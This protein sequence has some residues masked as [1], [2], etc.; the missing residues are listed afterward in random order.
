MK[1]LSSKVLR[2]AL[3]AILAICMVVGMCTTALATGNDVIDTEAELAAAIAAGGE[4]VLGGNI[5]ITT[6]LKVTKDVNLDLNGY[7]LTG[8]HNYDNGTNLY[9]F[10]VEAGTLTLDDS[11]AAQTGEISCKYSG[12]ETKGGTFIM[13]GGKITAANAEYTVAVVNY[14]G[15]VVING[16]VI[17]AYDTA[18]TTMAYFTTSATTEIKGGEINLVESDHNYAIFEVGGEYNNGSTNVNVSAGEFNS[19]GSVVIA[20]DD[21][22][23]TVS[24]E[25]TGGAFDDDADISDYIAD[26]YTLG[27]N[28]EIIVAQKYVAI[29]DS[30]SNGYGTSGYYEG[31]DIT[32]Y[33]YYGF[34]REAGYPA[35][36][37]D[38]M[39]WDLAD[40]EGQLAISGM[41]AE[42][43]HAILNDDYNGDAYTKY[44]FMEGGE[45]DNFDDWGR[46]CIVL[47]NGVAGHDSATCDCEAQVRAIFTEQIEGA[48]YISINLGTNTFGTVF[49]HELMNVVSEGWDGEIPEYDAL[50]LETLLADPVLSAQYNAVLEYAKTK[51]DA[52]YVNL[53]DLFA[54]SYVGYLANYTAAFDLIREI[55]PDATIII[56]GLNNLLEGM[57]LTLGEG[58]AAIPVGD[59]VGFMIDAANT[60]ISAISYDDAKVL[61]AE[62]ENLDLMINV[63]G[64]DKFTAESET[65]FGK[66]LAETVAATFAGYGI[67]VPADA[68]ELFIFATP[69]ERDA[70]VTATPGLAQIA[71]FWDA[72]VAG[73]SVTELDVVDVMY[74]MGTGDVLNPGLLH[75]MARATLAEGIGIHPST[76]GHSQIAA[77]IKAAVEE[78]STAGDFAEGNITAAVDGAID[79]ITEYYDEA[80]AYAYDYADENGYIDAAV[81]AIDGVI[82]T[83]ENVDLTA[84]EMT[85]A[86]RADAAAAIAEVIET[87]EA[88]KALLLAADELDEDTLNA[89]IAL[90]NDAY[91]DLEALDE[92]FIQAAVDVNQLVIIPAINAAIDQLEKVD[93]Y[94]AGILRAVNDGYNALIAAIVAN[95]ENTLAGEYVIS[96]D[97]AY[98]AIGDETAYGEL[99]AAEIGLEADQFVELDSDGITVLNIADV[100]DAEGVAAVSAADLITVG[101]GN[102]MVLE[103]VAECISET[104]PVEFDWAA[105]VTEAGVPYVEKALAEVE[106]Y[107]VEAG[108]EG[109]ILDTLM[110]AVEAYAYGYTAMAISVPTLVEAI[111]EINSE[112]LVIMVG[113]YNPLEGVVLTYEDLEINL[114]EYIGYF[115]DAANAELFVYALISENTMYVD[116]PNVETSLAAG[117]YKAINFV[118]GLTTNI[119]KTAP[120]AAGHE[121]IKDQIMNALTITV[122]ESG[123]IGDVN[124]DGVVNNI[125]ATL[126][127]RYSVGA[128]SEE[129]LAKLYIEVGNVNGDEK[130]NNID[131]T[132][133]LRYS[134][135]AVEALPVA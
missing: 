118:M 32:A 72:F 85:D 8:P 116:A 5:E 91:A 28:G 51:L 68:L 130:V 52:K 67:S 35:K 128:L 95:Y 107:F 65:I 38:L 56:V 11:S 29:G 66:K 31:D 101:F 89:V 43:L 121:Y 133:I 39:G 41:R 94:I 27:S 30:M 135:G 126:V 44:T 111:R 81:D 15:S 4:V 76:Y 58:S 131:A 46:F 102:S 87:L 7:V 61:Y 20:Y 108:V 113:M 12:I 114:G 80:Y 53:A 92:V 70:M 100:L 104:E 124:G 17:N 105:I 96:D 93:A 64:R 97:S 90:L 82:V 134:V 22:A 98:V 9:A 54:Y 25:I 132:I 3:S 120:T 109:E 45:G 2:S 86:F 115:V 77:A 6:T 119:E 37:A 18:V 122:E 14:G 88:A 73:A 21:H 106:A 125:D 112:A 99:V 24:A 117:E 42:E 1:K 23:G 47:G 79:I 63:L 127:L 55:N 40:G 110:L 34:Q 123:L 16:G 69:E 83:L 19:N 78:N 26:G 59:I 60:Y 103:F 10:I 129:Q 36:V 57:S 74:A 62:V 33:N 50:G 84:V 13:N 71:A 75:L 49:I 48:D